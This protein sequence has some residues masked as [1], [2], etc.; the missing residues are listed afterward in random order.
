[1]A[2]PTSNSPRSDTYIYSATL[3][4]PPERVNAAKIFE[5]TTVPTPAVNSSAADSPTM[6]PTERMQPVTMPSSEE[7]STMVRIIC[8]FE[9]PSP[10]APSR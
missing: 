5:A 10:S 1:M 4:L 6:R 7:G 8:H 3:R 9:A 2:K